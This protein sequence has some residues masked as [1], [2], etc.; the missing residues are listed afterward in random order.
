MSTVSV[1]ETCDAGYDQTFERCPYCNTHNMM[2]HPQTL[3][4]LIVD[5]ETY[6]AYWLM[7]AY[8][9]DT[10][11]LHTFQTFDGYPLDTIGMRNVLTKHTLVT[12]N[13]IGYDLPIITYAMTGASTQQ[14]KAAS[15]DIIVNQLK[16][17]NFYRQYGLASPDSLDHIDL[18]EVA[19]GQ[20]SLKAFGGKMHT[21]K[22]QDLPYPPEMHVE[23]PHRV[24]LR[25][26]CR[27]DI[28]VTLEL[29]RTLLDRIVM[30][31][32]IGAKFGIDVRSKSDP[33]IAE[34][35]MRVKLGRSPK[36]PPVRVGWEFTYKPP[37]W[38][39]FKNLDILERLA[40]CSFVITESGSVAPAYHATFIDWSD[41]SLRMDIHGAWVARPK[42][43]VARPLIINGTQYTMGIG[44][45]HSMEANITWRADTQM[46]LTMPDVGSYY[47]SLILET[48][49]YPD[50][51]G[52]EFSANYRETYDSRLAAKALV[53][54]LK[55]ELHKLPKVL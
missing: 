9:P 36:A 16:H 30:R 5:V 28:Q 14:L 15:D 47:P 21:R 26:Y 4:P 35:I 12:F 40:E 41:K 55:K 24:L 17:W 45:L 33:Q 6:A 13:G 44:G 19:P 49:I 46:S 7:L 20:G 53:G 48:G 32:K 27:N 11:T 2:S 23:W 31:E 3:T 22:L 25:E 37:A 50:A 8:A 38:L 51:I 34:A 43:W 10:D 39:K 54:K 18:I 29:Y 1:C 52:P 42:G